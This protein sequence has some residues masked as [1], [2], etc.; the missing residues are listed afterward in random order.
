[1][2]P[3]LLKLRAQV[4]RWSLIEP[5]RI[6]GHTWEVAELLSVRLERN[7]R[8]GRG[9]AAGVY[10][11]GETAASMMAQV[12]SVRGEIEKGITRDSLQALLPRGGARNAVDCALWD[13]DAK[14]ALS[15]WTRLGDSRRRYAWRD[16]PSTKA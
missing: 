2:K 11:N 1:V 12:R 13:L 15:S 5:F 4:E 16:P 14:L 6:A 9:E 3:P 10:Y 8:A 7:G